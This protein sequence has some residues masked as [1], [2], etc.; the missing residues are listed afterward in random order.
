MRKALGIAVATAATPIAIAALFVILALLGGGWFADKGW[1]LVATSVYT[2]TL[3]AVPMAL[4]LSLLVGMPLS[5]WLA[6]RGNTRPRAFFILGAAIGALPFLLFDF[7]VIAYDLLRAY[8]HGLTDDFWGVLPTLGRFVVDIPVATYW[9]ALGSW[10]GAWSA[11]AYW[12][13]VYGDGPQVRS[14]RAV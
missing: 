14:D 4:V 6:K 12:G 3:V 10:C 8:R 2:Y 7:Y 9:L 11:L 1:K 13:V 5:S